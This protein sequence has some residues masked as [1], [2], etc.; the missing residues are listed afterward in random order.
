VNCHLDS[1]RVAH[2][3]LF[4]VDTRLQVRAELNMHTLFCRDPVG[5]TTWED[6]SRRVNFAGIVNFVKSAA[7]MFSVAQAC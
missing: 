3:A 2:P 5:G 7:A 1:A 6:N 4:F